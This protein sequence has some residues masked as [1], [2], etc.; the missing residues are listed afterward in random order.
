MAE[1][2]TIPVEFTDSAQSYKQLIDQL[3][4][5]LDTLKPGTGLY[6]SIKEQINKA[7]EELKKVDTKLDIG[8]VTESELRKIT[9]GFS[10]ISNLIKRINSSLQNIDIGDLADLSDAQLFSGDE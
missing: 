2:I 3:Q 5:Q 1:K 4:K 6:N 7:K 8:L 9:S 10:T